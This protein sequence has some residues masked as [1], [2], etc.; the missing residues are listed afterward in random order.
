MRFQSH[1]RLVYA[2]STQEN[3]EGTI[4]G[5]RSPATFFRSSRWLTPSA[6]NHSRSKIN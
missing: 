5:A 1:E 6:D 4:L 3:Q 2:V